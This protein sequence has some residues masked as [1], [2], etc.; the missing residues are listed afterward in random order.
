[1]DP[2]GTPRLLLVTLPWTAGRAG[3]GGVPGVMVGGGGGVMGN[4]Y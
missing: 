2:F 1:M 4:G 3:G